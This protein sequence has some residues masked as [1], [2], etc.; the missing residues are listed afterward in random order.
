MS[1]NRL[2]HFYSFAQKHPSWG[3]KQLHTTWKDILEDGHDPN[4]DWDYGR[5]GDR[6]RTSPLFAT[7]LDDELQLAE[8]LL[9]YGAKIE[10]RNLEGFTALHEAIIRNRK[11]HVQLFLDHGADLETQVISGPL[12]GGTAVHVAVAEGVVDMIGN[13]LQRGANPQARTRVGWTAV[14]IAILDRQETVLGT[15]LKYVDVS[16][17]LSDVSSGLEQEPGDSAARD[18]PSAI[19]YHL[20]EHGISGTERRHRD[21]YL[22]CLTKITRAQ[23]FST[24]KSTEL[25][26]ILIR[27]IEAMLMEIAGSP[28]ALTWSRNL[29]SQ[30]ER[31][32]SQD[33][34]NMCKA[35]EHS[36]DHSALTSSASRGC[37][38]CLFIADSLRQHWCLL[39]QISKEWR[40]EFGIN[41]SVRLRIEDERKGYPFDK[42]QIIMVCGDKI[43][44]ID[45]HQ[46]GKQQNATIA[47]TSPSD[48]EGTG[49]DRSLAAAKAWL[50]RCLEE[51][52]SCQLGPMGT[53][54]TRV[55]EVGDESTSPYIYISK[56]EEARYVALSCFWG[57]DQSFCSVTSN[58]D[59]RTKGIMLADMPK[60][61]REAV[62][63]ARKFG[64]QYLWV[65]A[66]CILQ[67]SEEDI[68]HE[69]AC[70]GDI[71]ANAF[72]TIAAK[73]SPSCHDGLFRRR[74]SR[75]SWLP[76][77]FR[78]PSGARPKESQ[79]NDR[80]DHV[81]TSNINRLMVL[82]SSSRWPDDGETPILD[83][84][85]WA[86][87]EECL[88]RRT[89]SFEKHELSW[90]CVESTCSEFGPSNGVDHDKW[91]YHV[92]RALVT[93]LSGHGS[94][95]GVGIERVFGYWLDIVAEFSRRKISRPADKLSAIAALQA[96]IGKLL[97]DAPVAGMWRNRYFVQSLLWK[98]DTKETEDNGIACRCPS[99]SWASVPMPITYVKPDHGE[100]NDMK[101]GH[102][103][104][105]F[106]E[107]LS[108]DGIVGDELDGDIHG[109]V[110]LRCK[111]LRDD[112]LKPK[113]KE[114]LRF[115]TWDDSINAATDVWLMIVRTSQF[116]PALRHRGGHTYE[117][118][119]K[120]L[121]LERI[122][123]DR[124]DFR[125]I[126]LAQGTS[127][128]VRWHARARTEEIR[129][130]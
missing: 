47:R 99:W 39:T 64:I 122:A 51:H 11:D 12:E 29:C 67:D 80:V 73:S 115:E 91:L 13:F 55:I 10:T 3:G 45:L 128:A 101:W 75:T 32:Q 109:W 7:V 66:L 40:E 17:T 88:S 46:L 105:Y 102:D 26:R 37:S 19:A 110:A 71:Y 2:A 27:E 81:R 44:F 120:F 100:V 61:L 30:C 22:N 85:A 118:D 16:T 78:L 1:S 124:M 25:A 9:Q 21:L 82:S 111:L 90:S 58:I 95:Q 69:Q 119:T 57:D 106:P 87:Q 79:E 84:R 31:V 28:G 62:V 18:N 54:P 89:L 49:S 126:G 117:I 38:L 76:L 15:L 34:H 6:I 98:V 5:R 50:Q 70:M 43:A 103:T 96:A 114:A 53:L 93:G 35:F 65:G 68:R 24:E 8:L 42:Y 83:T 63:V 97:E 74:S 121:R 59:E 107:V 125:R 56:G 108:W 86:L 116:V 60:T 41:S 14:D 23:S 94:V 113:E 33:A 127:K 92:K 130:F 104:I 123:P 48:A 52:P 112:D 20:I 77:D 129:L 36:P 4:E 72:L